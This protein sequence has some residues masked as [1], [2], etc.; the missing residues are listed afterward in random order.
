M[1]GSPEA[2]CSDVDVYDDTLRF[3]GQSSVAVRHGERN[4]LVWTC[5]DFGELTLLLILAFDN[6][7]DDGRMVAPEVDKDV[8]DAI[9][10]QSLE[11]GER[12]CIAVAC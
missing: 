6:S 2:L 1:H 11:E 8:R 7:L 10:P 4:H 9:L 3:A 12:S 5:D